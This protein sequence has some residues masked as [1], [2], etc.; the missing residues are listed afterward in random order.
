MNQVRYN[1]VDDPKVT[2]AVEVLAN[3]MEHKG[4][5]K[6]VISTGHYTATV[7]KKFE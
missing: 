5:D 1:V 7:V 4:V 3:H 6:L 2:E